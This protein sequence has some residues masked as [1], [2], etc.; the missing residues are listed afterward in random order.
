VKC[1]AGNRYDAHSTTVGIACIGNVTPT[2]VAPSE[3]NMD[4]KPMMDA[5]LGWMLNI[6]TDTDIVAATNKMLV[7]ETLKILD[8]IGISSSLN[9]ITLAKQLIVE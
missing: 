9:S 8:S 3:P 5:S 7:N 1:L 6:K 2:M 4:I